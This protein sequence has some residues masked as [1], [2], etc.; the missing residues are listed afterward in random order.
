MGN[1][2][3]GGG[4]RDTRHEGILNPVASE[5]LLVAQSPLPSPQ[6][7]NQKTSNESK[8]VPTFDEGR[9]KE[10]SQV[11]PL[12]ETMLDFVKHGRCLLDDV[13]DSCAAPAQK[14][15]DR[16]AKGAHALKGAA[17][18]PRLKIWQ[19]GFQGGCGHDIFI[20]CVELLYETL[21]KID[22]E[23]AAE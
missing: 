5:D 22:M 13:A 20:N 23:R 6:H 4:G 3:G 17:K 10:L 1:C 21:L 14:T 18:T 19:K 12:R 7:F 15:W 16:T 8:L 2:F 9:L 11:V